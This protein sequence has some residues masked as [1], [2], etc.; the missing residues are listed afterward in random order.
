M[1]AGGVFQPRYLVK[2][3]MIQLIVQRGKGGLKIAE[4]HQPARLRIDGAGD[5]NFD[6]ERMA[7]QTR[8]F[9]IG[10]GLG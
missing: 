9:V 5:C 1:L 7:M 10:G 2:I 4:I 8:T 6:A 3:S